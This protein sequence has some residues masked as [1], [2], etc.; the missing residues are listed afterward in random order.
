MMATLD[1]V[2]TGIHAHRHA[3][4]LHMRVATT[5]SAMNTKGCA[6][7]CHMN[8]HSPRIVSSTATAILRDRMSLSPHDQHTAVAVVVQRE[9]LEVGAEDAHADIIAHS[10]PATTT[11]VNDAVLVDAAPATA[12]LA[13][14][15]SSWQ[16]SEC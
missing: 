13:S 4:A 16:S 15:A 5:I 11:P 1:S 3:C 2:H 9:T 7:W 6:R 12:K 10:Q 8:I 14:V